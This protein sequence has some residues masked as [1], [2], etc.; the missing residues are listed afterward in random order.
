M[1]HS[2]RYLF[3]TITLA[4][5]SHPHLHAQQ[6][7][8]QAPPAETS[9]HPEDS[10]LPLAV[11]VLP[12]PTTDPVT[13]DSATQSYKA[14]VYT[15]DGAVV[16]TLA[17]VGAPPRIIQADH[18]EYDSNSGDLTATG[19]LVLSGGVNQERISASHG[20]LNIR[21][22]TGRFYDV[23]GSVGMSPSVVRHRMV[24]TTDS[25]FLFTGRLVVKSGPQ[26]YDVY[27][28][29]VTSC[30]LP[31]PD[32]LLASAHI[33]VAPEKASAHNSTFRL[34]NVPILFLPYV[35]HP[36][37]GEA[38]QS[39]FVIPTFGYSSTRGVYFG[40]EFY[41]AINRST[42]LTV[43]AE[44]F[45]LRGFS[46]MVAFRYR[47]HGA[48]FL[49]IRYN[50]LLD[51]RTGVDASGNPKNQGGE[52]ATI[53]GRHDFSPQTRI[54]GNLEYLSSYIYREAFS[55]SFNQAITSDIVST[56]Y[57]THQSHGVEA[58][59]LFDRYQGIK[60]I[61]TGRTAQNPLPTGQQQ[62]RIFHVPTLS[63]STTD[64]RVGAT[65]LQI[66]LEA[67][68]SGLK[69][70]QP[71]F[72]TGGVVERFDLHPQASYPLSLGQWRVVPSIATRE[73]LYTRSRI[74]ASPGQPAVESLS[75][76]ARA[77]VEFALSIRPPVITRTFAPSRM[78]AILGD[79][80]RHTIEP[81]LTY[82]LTNGI[83]NFPKILRFDATDVV[84]NTDEAEYGITQRLF[85]RK[86][87]AGPCTTSSATSNT[88]IASASGFNPT[89][90]DDSPNTIT[91]QK[92]IAPTTACD[93]SDEFIS[94]RLTQ[95][96]FF[97][98][99][100]GGAVS[101]GRRN[102]FESTLNLSGVAF[103]TERRAISPLISRLRV[104]TSARTDIE[105]DFDLD[106]GA[107][108]F[109][110]SNVFIDVHQKNTFAA[111]S[112]ARL[113]APGRFYTQ[114]ADT[115]ATGVTTQISDFNQ[116]RVLLG[117]GSPTKRGLS[118]AGNAGVD[119][120]SLYGATS[121]T[122]HNGVTT[123]RTAYPALF[124]YSAIQASYNWNCCGVAF[125]YRR[126]NLGAIHNE[127]GYRFNFTLANVGSAGNLR[128]AERLF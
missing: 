117:Y 102:I 3:I 92:Q 17:T 105:W 79:E 15:L 49:T 50:G 115:S 100:F 28:G 62:V 74:P 70:S 88:S 99:D 36:I 43:G 124:Q 4:L 23:S 54:A 47:G 39:G 94:W 2:T 1:Q 66:S 114:G 61:A 83:S 20:T 30:Q 122:T 82:R 34:L 59:A 25:P 42:D 101:L 84:S 38:R 86:R 68:A 31:H 112:Y 71:N 85:R 58:S 9:S 77:D 21:T 111:L 125:E 107:R 96:Y 81:Q 91:L 55:N 65:G 97:D 76:I 32:W 8:I 123:T 95:K 16:I 69:R 128:R 48:D 35:T 80:L 87:A 98:Q 45:S 89:P 116:L 64:H 121:T 18:I 67:S 11:P 110:S 93:S 46:Q 73:T 109:T 118:L 51:R 108:K 119:L 53:A 13:I 7:T 40:E 27:D 127:P 14:G 120:K 126:F 29:T 41:L 22:A 56:A 19:H 6:L 37:D 72:A 26:N 10:D 113:D 78:K 106:T 24:Y 75:G 60:V 103:L 63:F 90:D 57:L 33:S 104:R 52:D 5:A 12:L 44:Y